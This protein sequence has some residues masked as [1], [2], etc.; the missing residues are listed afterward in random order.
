MKNEIELSIEE[1]NVLEQVRAIK[2][3]Y[4]SLM[5]YIIIVPLLFVVNYFTSPNYFWAIWPAMGWGI[6]LVCHGLSAFKIIDL[7]GA[8]WEKRQVEKRLAKI[9]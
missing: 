8:D 6:G 4:S 3:F 1:R 9:C 2:C 7:F 5:S